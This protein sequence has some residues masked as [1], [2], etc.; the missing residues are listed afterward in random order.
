[1]PPRK[2]PLVSA[3]KLYDDL[4]YEYLFDE[5]VL[6]RHIE[7]GTDPRVVNQPGNDPPTQ[8]WRLKAFRKKDAHLLP[9]SQS[10]YVVRW[11]K[12][13]RKMMKSASPKKKSASPKKKIQ[14]ISEEKRRKKLEQETLHATNE[15]M[16]R[17]EAKDGRVGDDPAGAI[18]GDW[19]EMVL[20]KKYD[21]HFAALR[22]KQ[23]DE[24]PPEYRG[25]Y[26]VLAEMLSTHGF[27]DVVRAAG[28][29]RLYYRIFDVLRTPTEGSVEHLDYLERLA[30]VER[31]TQVRVVEQLSRARGSSGNLPPHGWEKIRDFGVPF[32]QFG[33]PFDHIPD[34]KGG[35]MPRLAPVETAVVKS[36][37][38]AV[39][40]AK[41]WAQ[42]GA[43]GAVVT[44][45]GALRSHRWK[46]KPMYDSE[47]CFESK[48]AN[49]ASWSLRG[50]APGKPNSEPIVVTRAPGTNPDA[51]RDWQPGDV[52][53]YRA[54][55]GVSA[56]KEFFRVRNDREFEDL[57]LEQAGIG[58]G[59]AL[60]RIKE[61][62][63]RVERATGVR[64]VEARRVL[65]RAVQG[66][67]K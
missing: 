8:L 45:K 47:I 54:R 10:K 7:A 14:R 39:E 37:A 53:G 59:A 15:R 43:E 2:G 50:R 28:T 1:M 13:K 52:V 48:T 61:D 3:S 32:V 11:V 25:E 51:G 34:G 56:V 6:L 33:I 46:I 60:R 24:G 29:W 26:V 64:D 38:E 22:L 67:G 63:V 55:Y 18:K 40:V 31:L 19:R 27:L 4:L 65:N 9:H 66:I 17:F 35:T 44:A 42:E 21:G 58:G 12:Q 16:R 41:R 57:C 20:S 5:E 30:L 49:K 23:L 62:I 36:K